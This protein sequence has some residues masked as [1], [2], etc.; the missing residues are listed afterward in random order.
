MNQHKQKTSMVDDKTAHLL[1]G[2]S[3]AQ[4]LWVASKMF[5]TARR[6]VVFTLQGEHPDWDEKRVNDRAVR[7][8]YGMMGKELPSDYPSA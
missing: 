5:S 7:V 2:M 3:G 6:A 1:R 8:L 4:K